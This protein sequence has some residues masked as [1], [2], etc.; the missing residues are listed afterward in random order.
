MGGW[1]QLQFAEKRWPT[2]AEL[3]AAAPDHPVI[4]YQGFNGPA[5]TNSRGKSFFESRGVS[6]A[7]TG[8]IAEQV[9]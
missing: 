1:N 5:A 2:L 9:E 4:L 3:D 7:T 6:V 8:E